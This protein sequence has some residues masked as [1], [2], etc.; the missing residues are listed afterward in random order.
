[1]NKETCVICWH[2]KLDPENTYDGKP[3]NLGLA[4][5]MLE[6]LTKQ[7]PKPYTSLTDA[8]ND[9]VL[10]LNEQYPELHHWVK[11]GQ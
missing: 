7:Q 11:Q 2:K 8:V 4:L 5:F 1:M 6:D 3:F 9:L 10:E